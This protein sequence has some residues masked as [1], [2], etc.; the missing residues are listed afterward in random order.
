MT[1]DLGFYFRIFLRRLPYFLVLLVLGTAA[2]LTLA[3]I[4][5]PVYEAEATLI[6]ESEQ[7]PDKLAASTVQ[8]EATEQLQIIQQRILTRDILLE[9]AN[10]LDIYAGSEF[11]RM[12]ADEKV[13]D[14]RNRI[15]IVTTGGAASYNR[16]AQA[17]IVTVGF[18][19]PNARMAAAVTNEL[20]TLILQENLEMRTTVA[21][22]TLDFFTRE[23]QRLDQDLARL[24]ARILSFQEENLN[25]LPDSLEFRRAQQSDL[26]ERLSQL[27]REEATIRDRRSRLVE[28]YERTGRVT[29]GPQD[30]RML[31][32]EE[33]RLAQLK[34]EYAS[35]VAVL[36][37][38]NPKVTVLK[39]RIAA[40]E[41]TV[42][43][44]R[45]ERSGDAE[46]AE[47]GEPMTDYEL[48]LADLDGQLEYISETKARIAAQMDE[49][50]A[51][52]A[53]TPGNAVTLDALQRDYRNVQDQYNQA[54][55]NRARAETGDMIES[56]SKGQRI[57]VVE[58][59]IAPREPTR[60]N[61]QKVAVAGVGAGLMA[62]L[63]LVLLL[64][65]LNSAVRRPADLSAALGIT[66][67]GAV[68]YIR[69]R[70]EIR[71]RRLILFTAFL[72]VLVG[73]P[74]GLWLVD[75]R[76]TPLEPLFNRVLERV[77]LAAMDLAPAVPARG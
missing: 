16:P 25:A 41:K 28:L 11:A 5:P 4:L 34:E 19:A 10:R 74:A 30:R 68:S 6:V 9:M 77:N 60:P 56:L 43:E 8:T 63:G 1:M 31:S 21:G 72:V 67:F 3:V 53:A 51:S 32:P 26:Q 52:I 64:E 57:T 14:L 76:V 73:V 69:T 75:T 15:S 49:L 44:Q 65:V 23:V 71:R 35:S 61:R 45:A 7:I 20:V 48:E 24:S 18:E 54:V 39:A 46:D 33:Q 47:T 55:A 29:T 17:T 13:E 59:A 58:Q 62:G 22:Q 37:L 2:G 42:A 36:S 50:S 40:L 27:E 66:A 38:E 12:P 70:E